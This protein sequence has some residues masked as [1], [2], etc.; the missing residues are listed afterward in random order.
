MKFAFSTKNVKTS[1]FLELC[2]ITKDYSFQGFEVYDVETF[3]KQ[4]KENVFDSNFKAG[5][6]RKLV[7]RHID[8]SA[9]VYPYNIDKNTEEG[10]VAKYVDYAVMAGT[11]NVIITLSDTATKEEVKKV[12]TPAV[13]SAEKFGVNLLIETVGKYSSTEE[14]LSVINYFETP[15]LGVSLNVRETFFNGKEIAD[16]TIQTLGAYINYV[17]LGDKKGDRNVLI[18]DGELPVDEYL[19]AFR[20]LNYDGFIVADWNDDISSYDIVL[21]HFLSYLNDR[22]ASEKPI[23]EI[24]YNRSKT[25]TFPWK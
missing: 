1:S 12:L 7:N 25:G 22:T 10:D 21:T 14:I 8:V 4:N 13:K 9:V 18:G 11:E 5:A 16:K 6:K 3:K 17:R 2:N 20:S 15:C 23:E 24:Y 19:M